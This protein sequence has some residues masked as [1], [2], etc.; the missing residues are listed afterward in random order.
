MDLRI[1][2][3]DDI[4]VVFSQQGNAIVFNLTVSAVIS[5]DF[6]IELPK[7]GIFI[8]TSAANINGFWES[9][10]VNKGTIE[11]VA[12][13][14][15]FYNNFSLLTTYSGISPDD[16]SLANATQINTFVSTLKNTIPTVSNGVFANLFDLS[17]I[18]I[19]YSIIGDRVLANE[20]FG[21]NNRNTLKVED[22]NINTD[23]FI[24]NDVFIFENGVI[25]SLIIK[26][27]N[28]NGYNLQDL[29]TTLE[30]ST[31]STITLTET[32]ETE[33]DQIVLECQLVEDL[34]LVVTA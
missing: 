14:N 4:E 7:K 21:Y 33:T 6:K 32:L 31:P 24:E 30:L 18:S 29:K 27:P 28:I 23:Q 5:E 11:L 10:T 9:D 20:N 3:N 15:S 34:N 25:F 12:M 1:L 22:F 13:A 2:D 16:V 26:M 19:T 17:V 8:G